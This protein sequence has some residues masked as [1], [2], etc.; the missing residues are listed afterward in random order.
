MGRVKS[1]TIKDV[2]QEAGVSTATVSRVLNHDVKVSA[3]TRQVVESAVVRLGYRVNPIARSLRSSDTHTIGIISPEFRNDFFMAVAEGIEGVLRD[4]GYTTFILNSRESIDEERSRMELLVQKQVDGAIIIPAGNRGDH[5]QILSREGIPYVLVDRYIEGMEAD[6]VITDNIRGAFLAVQRALDDGARRIAMISGDL[7]ISSARE[8]FI[9]Y[10][11]ALK[12]YQLSTADQAVYYGDL[13]IESGYRGME[14]ILKADPETTHVFVANMFMHL[15]AQQFMAEHPQYA[16]S[17]RFI[18]FDQLPLGVPWIHEYITVR[19]PL[20]L[21]GTTAAQC[22]LERIR[23][24]NTGEP[25]IY[26]LK[27]DIIAAKSSID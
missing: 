6:A 7:N 19:Q 21:I 23:G 13:H 8:R 4:E 14:V 16:S 3:A 17:I 9:G 11:R 12:I 5:Y 20:E 1:A 15:G 10:E 26:R 22:L 25:R 2:A 18:A 27:P 24:T